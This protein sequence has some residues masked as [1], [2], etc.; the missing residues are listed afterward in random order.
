M[1]VTDLDMER[2]AVWTFSLTSDSN[3]VARELYE[4]ITN[5]SAL[6]LLVAI[7]V[8]GGGAIRIFLSA[9]G[10]NF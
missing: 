10:V 8:F 3:I 5:E 9:A 6:V 1:V 4:E 7:F 2:I